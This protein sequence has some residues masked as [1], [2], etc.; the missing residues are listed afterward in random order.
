MA[1]LARG[2]LD[3]ALARFLAEWRPLPRGPS[4][5]PDVVPRPLRRLHELADAASLARQ[6]RLVPS[7]ELTAGDD[8][9]LI[10]YVENQG[11]CRWATTA[12]D[13]PPVWIAFDG[14]DAGT[15]WT[16]EVPRLSAFVLQL[17]IFET[18]M[19]S[20]HGRIEMLDREAAIGLEQ[21]LVELPLPSWSWPWSP[22]RF[23]ANEHVVA[24]SSQDDPTT[25]FIAGRDAGVLD[26][27]LVR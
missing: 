7:A 17:A 23:F 9:K 4:L 12:G 21:A 14:K 5:I 2:E 13:D 25:F 11:V 22:S 26:D 18:A 20:E 15:R 6:N 24:L 10:F 1:H 19:S 3:D 8:G 27:L 16:Y